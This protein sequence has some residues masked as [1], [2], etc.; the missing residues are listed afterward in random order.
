MKNIL[1]DNILLRTWDF[2]ERDGSIYMICNGTEVAFIDEDGYIRTINYSNTYMP[3]TGL[4]L[5][6]RHSNTNAMYRWNFG[7]MDEE[8]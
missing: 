2:I 6:V 8:K 7:G 4:P 1:R 5:A 3:I